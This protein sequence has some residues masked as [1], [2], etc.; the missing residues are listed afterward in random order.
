MT[1][2]YSLLWK[3]TLPLLLL[4]GCGNAPIAVPDFV[5]NGWLGPV[6]GADD[7]C[8]S[9]HTNSTSI[10]PVHHNLN[11]CLNLLNGAIFMQGADFNTLVAGRDKLCTETGSCTYEQAQLAKKLNRVIDQ[12]ERVNPG[13]H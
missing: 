12:I 4:E 11:D 5:V 10:A 8:S 3:V 13:R 2:R 6:G 7:A 9:V 1:Q